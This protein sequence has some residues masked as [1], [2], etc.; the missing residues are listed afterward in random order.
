MK[1]TVKWAAQK[2]GLYE[3]AHQLWLKRPDW[4]SLCLN[5]GYRI[6]KAPDGLPIP[7]AHLIDAVILSKEIAWF[8]HSG[9]MTADSIRYAL[10][11]NGYAVEN[12]EA[13]LDF[14]C[15]CGRVLRHWGELPNGHRLYGTDM[16]PELI[17]WDQKHLNK[18][19]KFAVN[20]LEPPLD[21]P[22]ES[23]DFVYAV[24]VFTHLTEG[25]EFAWIDELRRVLKPG[26]LL[27]IT[28]HGESRLYQL[29]PAEQEAFRLGS[30]VIKNSETPGSNSCGA[31]H[32]EAYVR[33]NLARNLAVIDFIPRGV[34]D[35]DQDIYLLQKHLLSLN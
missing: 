4:Q 23:F 10:L 9:R 6:C 33:N 3:F 28:V 8:L 31:Y 35:A 30:L 16:N 21:Y 18:I 12:F 24:S 20:R 29:S 17:A 32:P 1:Q 13:I 2:V 25:L 11:R 14:G 5:F 7:D 27:M 19:A 34:R 26:G 22:D 15:G